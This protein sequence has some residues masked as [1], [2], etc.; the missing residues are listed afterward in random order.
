VNQAEM[1][2]AMLANRVDAE[3]WSVEFFKAL[4]PFINWNI[5]LEPSLHAKKIADTLLVV[6]S[7]RTEADGKRWVHVSCSRPSRLP[8][9]GDIREVKD[10]FIGRERRALQVLP[11]AAEYVNIHPN[12]LHLWHCLDGDGMPDFRIQGM[13]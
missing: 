8:S 5:F 7:G 3:P 6:W 12:C 2:A 13:L 9:W 4:G 1:R 11:P 10:A